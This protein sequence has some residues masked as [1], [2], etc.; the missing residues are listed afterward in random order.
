MKLLMTIIFF[1]FSNM[2]FSYEA[3]S[4]IGEDIELDNNRTL[5]PHISN[6]Q[7]SRLNFIRTHPQTKAYISDWSQSFMEQSGEICK[8]YKGYHNS[9]VIRVNV[10]LGSTDRVKKAYATVNSHY[11][12]LERDIEELIRK[13]QPYKPFPK[14]LKALTN[15]ITIHQY[16]D[17]DILKSVEE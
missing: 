9:D 16:F 3:I 10:E 6:K 2:A 4:L 14:E 13:L 12:P 7:L 15:T 5:K 8:K 17:L 11:S 1:S